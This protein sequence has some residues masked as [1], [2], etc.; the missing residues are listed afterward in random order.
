[1]KINVLVGII[2]SNTEIWNKDLTKFEGLVEMISQNILSIE[3]NGVHAT[4]EKLGD[5][6]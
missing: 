6:Y 5:D 4:L 1:M 3:N 2:I